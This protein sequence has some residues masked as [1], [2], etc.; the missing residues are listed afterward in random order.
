MSIKNNIDLKPLYKD[1]ATSDIAFILNNRSGIGTT[2]PAHKLIL[3]C[4]SSVFDRMFYGGLNDE[5][6]IKIPDVC[7]E[8]FTEFLQFFYLTEFD[9]TTENIAEVFKLIDKYDTPGFWSLCEKHLE[10]TMTPNI[11]YLYYELALSF[12]LSKRLSERLEAIICED[13]KKAFQIGVTGGSNLLVLTNLLQ[14]NRLHCKEIDIFDGA[15]SWAKASL[16]SKGISD[17]EQNI[18]LELGDCI[19]YI[20]F[21]IMSS[22]EFLNCLEKFPNLLPCEEYFDI[23]QFITN[24]RP[25]SSAKHF[26]H[27][28]RFY[29]IVIKFDRSSAR[30]VSN[31]SDSIVT[32]ST[33]GIENTKFSITMRIC[34]MQELQDRQC[35]AEFRCHEHCNIIEFDENLEFCLKNS[36]T[37]DDGATVFEYVC[38]LENALMIFKNGFFKLSLYLCQ[39][40]SAMNLTTSTNVANGKG[41]WAAEINGYSFLSQ[42][43][44]KEIND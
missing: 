17:T 5:P 33:N 32:F 29:E 26:N 36:T 14:S 27:T 4:Q 24:Q 22:K 3:K 21:P 11:A 2:I 10:R 9:L 7:A 13:P 8:A 35:R 6:I 18:R 31:K 23:L 37:M 16:E 19:K 38:T 25:L 41:I 40:T 43:I 34:T 30:G 42:I 44:F 20:R 15:I 12:N 39:Y 28:R 1:S